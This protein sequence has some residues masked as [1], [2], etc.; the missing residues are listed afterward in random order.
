MHYITVSVQA[1]KLQHWVDPT[2]EEQNCFASNQR[3]RSAAP[4][5]L[6]CQHSTKSKYI[7]TTDN[8]LEGYIKT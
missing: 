6:N 8:M 2:V 1:D 7:N 3:F 4:T 5:P